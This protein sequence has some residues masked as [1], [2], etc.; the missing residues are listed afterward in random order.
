MKAIIFCL[1]VCLALSYD[2]GKAISYARKYCKNYNKNY[3]NYRNSGGDCANFVSQCLIAGGQSL[4]GCSGL[5]PKG[6]LPLVSNLENCLSNKGWKKST[7]KP[8]GFKAGHPFFI[9][10]QHAMI[11]T[12]VSG[13]SLKYCGHTTDRCDAGMTA[14]SNYVYFYL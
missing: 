5:D 3:R 6:T 9:H 12:S 1:L 11:A 14:K 8:G 13:N 7:G 10:N 4:S 2:T